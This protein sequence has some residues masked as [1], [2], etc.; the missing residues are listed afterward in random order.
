MGL[1]GIQGEDER[2][3]ARATNLCASRFQHPMRFELPSIP[4]RASSLRKNPRSKASNLA[5]KTQQRRWG[6]GEGGGRRGGEGRGGRRTCAASR[7]S[8]APN[9][10]SN[11]DEMRGGKLTGAVTNV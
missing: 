3:E 5:E 11:G 9:L 1:C 6:I 10:C 4:H 2:G 7:K 8:S